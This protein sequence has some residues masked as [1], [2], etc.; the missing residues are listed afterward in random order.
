MILE[1]VNPHAPAAL[2]NFWIDLTHQHP[3]FPE[4][5][6]I[7]CRGAGFGS[8]YVFHPGGTGDV[9]ADREQVGD[10]ALIAERSG[11]D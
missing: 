10:Y 5:L 9:D 7:L 8:A 2:K 11:E 4:V 3:V 6:L 1:T